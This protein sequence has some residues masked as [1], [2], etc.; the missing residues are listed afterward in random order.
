MGHDDNVSELL[1]KHS[2]HYLEMALSHNRRRRPDHPDG[3]GKRTGVCGDTVEIFLEIQADHITRTW[4]DTDG[5]LNTNACA[6]TVAQ[7]T[8]GQP[9]KR[10]WEITAEDIITYLESLPPDEH[11]CAELAVG[12]F[13]LALSD[14]AKYRQSPWKKAYR[15]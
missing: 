12:A 3:H 13:Y 1:N 6:N 15:K 4:F 5:C 9:V 14:Y 10:A 8:E 2:R 7:L 11:H